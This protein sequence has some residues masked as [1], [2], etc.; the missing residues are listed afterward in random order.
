[1]KLLNHVAVFLLSIKCIIFRVGLCICDLYGLS[2]ASTFVLMPVFLG[3][4]GEVEAVFGCFM[5]A[6]AGGGQE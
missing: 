6:N 2:L 4:A 1:M 3:F 5:P